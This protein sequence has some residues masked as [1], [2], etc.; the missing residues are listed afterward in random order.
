MA[1]IA[2]GVGI[3]GLLIIFMLIWGGMPKGN[4]KHYDPYCRKIP[5]VLAAPGNCFKKNGNALCK[6]SCVN[7]KF[8][9]GACLH[10]PKPQSKL[11][12]HCWLKDAKF[13]P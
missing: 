2:N 12:C 7:E 3:V 10:L 5:S 6:E 4:A 9:H 11:T 13:C 1:R 8:L